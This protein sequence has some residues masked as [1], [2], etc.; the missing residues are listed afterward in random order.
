MEKLE[1]GNEPQR[2]FADTVDVELRV[3]GAAYRLTLEP[4]CTLLD[5]LR[6]RLHLTG[7]KKSCDMGECGACTVLLDGKPV[8]SC[9]MLAIECQGH[10]IQ[11]IEGLS[12]NGVLDSI[13]TAFIE[14]DSYQCGFCTPGQIMAVRGLLLRSPLPTPDDIR[15]AISG[16]LCRCG[17]YPRIFKAAAAAAQV[18]EETTKK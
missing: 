17:A 6:D 5:A 15:I 7:T 14:Y 2:R 10:D 18:Y 12:K 13:Q 4:R 16:N 9:L 11:T 3:N 1:K 8:Y